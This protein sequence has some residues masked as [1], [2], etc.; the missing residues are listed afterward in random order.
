MTDCDMLDR[1]LNLPVEVVITQSYHFE[2]RP[3][4]TKEI[5]VQQKRL[6]QSE[7]KAED[8][9]DDLTDAMSDVAS[10]RVAMGWH[11]LSV[12]VKAADNQLAALDRALVAV[13]DCFID[14]NIQPHGKLSIS[15]PASGRS[16]RGIF[17]T[18]RASAAS[19]RRISRGL[20]AC[21]TSHA[22]DLTATGGAGRSRS[23]RQ[24]ARHRTS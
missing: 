15:K 16:C 3:T 19:P 24:R 2:D 6:D 7:D 1:F 14:L 13:E 20:R 23:W 9:I 21:T 11:H 4:S 5:E 12:L 17:S 10:G 22:G 8:Q 18:L